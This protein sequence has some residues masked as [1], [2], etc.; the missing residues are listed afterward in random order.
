ML[1]IKE[2]IDKNCLI[3]GESFS[4][5][6]SHAKFCSYDCKLESNRRRLN[7]LNH[8]QW[9]ILV[10]ECLENNGYCCSNC[11]CGENLVC[12]HIKPKILGGSDEI[13]NLT[14][15]CHK[16]HAQEHSNLRRKIN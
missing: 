4:S 2:K 11:G 6:Y 12:H 14:M 8:K 15:L 1:K 5:S 9:Q 13:E 10:E 3:C 16:C 7:N